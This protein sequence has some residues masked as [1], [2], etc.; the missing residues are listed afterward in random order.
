MSAPLLTSMDDRE[1]V[2]LNKRWADLTLEDE[3]NGISFATTEDGVDPVHEEQQYWSLIGRFLTAKQIKTK[4]MQNTLASVWRPPRGVRIIEIR[5]NLYEFQFFHPKE[6]QRIIDD[7]LWS[8]ENNMLAC[9]MLEAREQPLNVIINSVDIWLQI[10]ELPCGYTSPA[11]VE[12]IANFVGSFV[13]HDVSFTG[14]P[15]KCYKRVRVS[16]D[17]AKP[18]KRRMKLTK[19]DGMSVWVTFGY[20]RMSTFCFFC[21]LIGHTHQFCRGAM[22]SPL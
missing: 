3:E 14:A 6:A 11:V 4:Y 10:F 8:F 9:R 15:M 5:P 21:G 19:R 12:R 18:L 1:A 7:G 16:L 2:N 17:I 22:D 13:K 20:E